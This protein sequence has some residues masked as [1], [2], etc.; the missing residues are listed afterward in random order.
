MSGLVKQSDRHQTEYQTVADS[1][2]QSGNNFYLQ[3]CSLP[4]ADS[5]VAVQL[6]LGEWV[7]RV[8]VNI[9]NVK[10]KCGY[11]NRL[12]DNSCDGWD[13]INFAC[14]GIFRDFIVVC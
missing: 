3:I 4:I 10:P 11:I 5:S 7:Y 2:F 6:Q 9:G 8:L 13:V 14:W 1:I 12:N